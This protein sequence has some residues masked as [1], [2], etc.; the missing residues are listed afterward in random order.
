[1]N[2][3]ERIPKGKELPI[4]MDG[5]SVRAILAGR[6]T[7]TRRAIPHKLMQNADLDAN[8]PTYIY[9]EDAYGDSHRGVTYAPY[10]KDDLL[11]VKE[12]WKLWDWTEDGVPW[13]R[14]AADEALR[15]RDIP[16]TGDTFWEMETAEKIGNIWAKLSGRENVI[17]HGAARDG[18][19]RS[20]LF[21][22]KHFTRIWL[23]VTGVRAERLQDI[24]D[25]DAIAEGMLHNVDPSWEGNGAFA[26]GRYQSVWD[27]L[28]AKRGYPWED[29]PWVWVYEFE[30]ER[31]E[32]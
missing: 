23:R 31:M 2:K 10:K 14:Y 30:V 18:K 5:D 27:E 20:P 21:M 8:D 12:A 11:W 7:Q 24:T 16:D 6:K 22:Y 13:I 9:F 32:K 19:W 15:L 1:M 3:I 25:P 26:R 29:N 28:N 4:I 17:K